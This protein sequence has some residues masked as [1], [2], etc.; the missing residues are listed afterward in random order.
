MVRRRRHDHRLRPLP[1]RAPPARRGRCASR[2]RPRSC[3]EGGFVW[4]GMF[5]PEPGRARRRSGRA[6]ACTSSPSRTRRP[7]T[8]GPRSSST[9]A[10]SRSSSCAPRGTTTSARRSTSARSASSSA[11]ASSSPSARAWPA[12]CTARGI[13]SS[14]APSCCGRAAP[15]CCGRSSTRSST[16]YAPGRRR[17]R[18]RHRAG[19]GDRLRRRGRADRAHLLPAPRGHRL[20]PR[21]PPA[22][23][24]SSRRSSATARDT[25][26]LPYFRDVHDHLL[27][28]NEEVAAQRDL[29]ATILEANMAVIS[30][31]QTQVSVRQNATM[32]S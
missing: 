8:C 12:T 4:L 29:L 20:L 11:R 21:R 10:T 9:R 18:A 1:R 13:G 26:L 7:S 14:S 19:R 3:R 32:S 24:P 16:S 30:V 27:L 23:R 17:A 28:V 15:R 6:S 22:A 2:T 25:E 5:E 31:E